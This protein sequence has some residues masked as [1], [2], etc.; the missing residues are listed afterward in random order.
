MS[1]RNRTMGPRANNFPLFSELPPHVLAPNANVTPGDQVALSIVSNSQL[2]RDGLVLLLGSHLD[3]HLVGS[4]TGLVSKTAVLPNP[5]GHVV[6]LDG[7]MGC[8]PAVAWTR[9]WCALT[10]AAPVLVL[11]LEND[12]D[13][14]LACIEAGAKG[15]TLQGASAQEVAEVIILLRQG[16]TLCGADVVAEVFRRLVAYAEAQARPATPPSPL[17]DRELQVLAYIAEDYSNQRIAQALVIEVRTVKHHVH[18]ILE[19]LQLHHR[20]DAARF[21]RGQGWLAA[22]VPPLAPPNC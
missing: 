20:E 17:S 3:L 4:Y 22:D 16:R 7:S 19:K 9:R 5:S 14:I 18:N 1:T 11:E 10:P 8:A 6:L 12:V 15:Y 21:A 2:L 13:V